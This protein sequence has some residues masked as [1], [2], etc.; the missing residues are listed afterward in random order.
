MIYLDNSAT[1]KPYPEVLDAYIK[2]SEQ[3]F[4]NPSSLHKLG[5][6]SE[7]LLYKSR[8]QAAELLGVRESEIVFTSGGTEGNNAAIKG[9]A[10]G[11]QNRGKH[12]VTTKVEHPASLEAFKQL[13]HLGFD[14][15]YL[16]VD[17]EGR[18]SLEQLKK[19]VRP[20]TVLVSIIHVNNELGTI[21]PIQAI[22]D[23]LKACPKTLFHVDHVQGLVKVPLDFKKCGIDLCTMSGHKIHGPKGTGILYVKEGLKLSPLFAGGGQEM[24]RRSGTENLPGIVG[25]VKALRL[26]TERSK[27]QLSHVAALKNKIIKAFQEMTDV[28]VHTPDKGAA[29]HIINATIKGV[30]AEVLIHALEEEDIYISTKSACASKAA[31]VSTVLTACGI[32]DI[33]ARQAIRVSLSLDQTDEEIDVFLSVLTKKVAELRKVMAY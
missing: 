5:A 18:L 33:D 13:E 1:T 4:G 14:V 15:T 7:E 10:F 25:L 32:S 29:P 16:D 23:Y 26:S 8:L 2:A 22:G 19:A 11:Y 27:R 6:R 20:D 9:V 21:Q 31:E 24:G 17:H 28:A 3:Y 30:R 12:M